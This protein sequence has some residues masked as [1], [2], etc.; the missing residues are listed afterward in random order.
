MSD[1]WQR[2]ALL[3]EYQNTNG[4][5]SFEK[6]TVWVVVAY[7]SSEDVDEKNIFRDSVNWKI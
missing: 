7:G 4:S 1:L 3:C 6:V 2:W 5:T